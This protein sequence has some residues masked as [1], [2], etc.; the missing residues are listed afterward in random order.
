LPEP[1]Y[2][3]V[4]NRIIERI[5]DGS[6]PPGSMLPSEFDI[7]A[8]LGV[9]QGT[10]RKALIDLEKKGIIDRRQGRGTFVTLRTP[11]NSLFHFFRLRNNKGEQVVPALDHEVVTRRKA[12][13]AEKSGLFGEPVEV[14]EIFRIRSYRDQPIAHETS[15]V[16]V[17]LFP[18]LLE[19]A[20]LPNTLYVLFQQAYSCVII[21]AEESLKAG[22]LGAEIGKTL[23]R[24][25]AIPVIVA[26]RQGRD[27]LERV[28]ELR[29]S[30]F[31]T[32]T[33]TY[34]VSLD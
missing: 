19:R 12:T 29:T 9:S 21:S 14:F 32:E 27:I 28:V 33:V 13:S 3:V 18:G 20:P 31:L 22:V 34:S 2:R 7:G 30:I 16:S 23:K 1:L 8:E 25:P 11:E 10:A 5:V 24:D 26:T 6:Y 15:V 17:E 4:F